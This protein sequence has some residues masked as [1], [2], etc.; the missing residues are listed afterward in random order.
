MWNGIEYL[1]FSGA[2]TLGAS[3]LGLISSFEKN[4][5]FE[6]VRDKQIKGY[7]G[8]SIGALCSLCLLIR[9]D[10]TQLIELLSPIVS[11][12][13]N[14]APVFDISLMISNFGF[15]N[16]NTIKNAIKMI[17]N[18]AGL[19]ET[20]TL[21][22]LKTFFP[23]EFVC[24]S[25]NLTTMSHEYISSDSHPNL[26]VVDA[27]FMSM[28]VPFLFT[29]VSSATYDLYVDGVL[30]MNTPQCFDSSKT[31]CVIVHKYNDKYILNWPEYI[32]RLFVCRTQNQ[33]LMFQNY[34]CTNV[35]DIRMTHF[36]RVAIDMHI[37]QST[38]KRLILNGYLAGIM[39]IYP[40]LIYTIARVLYILLVLN[41]QSDSS[42]DE[43]YYK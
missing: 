41:V 42:N 27:I 6:E 12:F 2:G 15:D 25:T 38:V 10:S 28:C 21:S 29:P 11:S 5:N 18:K 22:H 39:Y 16:G 33:N 37:N 9:L 34:G 43:E 35:L 30:S 31:L 24:V 19:S 40:N 23:S 36:D 13:D 17:L 8:T 32:N 1:A 26:Q 20:I 4:S 14:I 3:Y 7:A